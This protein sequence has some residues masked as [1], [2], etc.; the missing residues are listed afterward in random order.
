MWTYHGK[1]WPAVERETQGT[2]VQMLWLREGNTGNGY[3][4]SIN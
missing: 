3:K 4:E 1:G 2:K